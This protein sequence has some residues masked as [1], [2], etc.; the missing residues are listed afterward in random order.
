V[1]ERW[2][3]KINKR[4]VKHRQYKRLLD[5][6]IWHIRYM[7]RLEVAILTVDHLHEGMVSEDSVLLEHDAASCSRRTESSASPL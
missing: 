7:F 4:D 6:T 1:N 2:I 5:K 3:S